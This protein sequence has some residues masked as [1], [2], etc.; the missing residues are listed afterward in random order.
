[1]IEVNNESGVPV[2]EQR[3]VALALF[4]LDA[5]RI[6]PQAE[7]SLLLVDEPFDPEL[8]PGVGDQVWPGRA[9]TLMVDHL[10]QEIREQ[11]GRVV[12]PM[13]SAPM[14]VIDA[15]CA[16]ALVA[17]LEAAGHSCVRDDGLIRCL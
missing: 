1:M 10:P 4:A 9:E 8:V 5:L 6:H 17:A 13:M 14:L 11:F 16:E 7:L 2:D 12:E 15:S 3:L